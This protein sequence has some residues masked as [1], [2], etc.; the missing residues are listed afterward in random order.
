MMPE[1]LIAAEERMTVA[2]LG[3]II[4]GDEIRRAEIPPL[5]WVH[6]TY[7]DYNHNAEPSEDV[8]LELWELQFGE[9]V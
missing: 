7:G 1:R 3:C 2:P 8:A 6:N 4:C 5:L 9:K